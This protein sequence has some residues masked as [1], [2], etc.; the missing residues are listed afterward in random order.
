MVPILRENAFRYRCGLR[1]N[2]SLWIPLM[3]FQRSIV[4]LQTLWLWQ[5]LRPSICRS[6]KVITASDYSCFSNAKVTPCHL[7]NDQE[8]IIMVH[9]LHIDSS[10]RHDRSLFPYLLAREFS[11]KLQFHL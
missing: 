9:I 1:T 7:F 4:T 2:I 11:D 10:P 6:R 3:R 5:A 8:A